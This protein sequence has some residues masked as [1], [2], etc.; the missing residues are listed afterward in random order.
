M[1][2]EIFDNTHWIILNGD[3]LEEVVM[4]Y[5]DALDDDC[6]PKN[7]D[8]FIVNHENCQQSALIVD[9]DSADED[10]YKLIEVTNDDYAENV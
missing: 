6:K 9:R 1:K 3:N 2:F 7:Q 10:G 4:E 8:I 5:I